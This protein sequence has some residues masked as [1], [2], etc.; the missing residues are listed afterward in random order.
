[1]TAIPKASVTASTASPSSPGRHRGTSSA[2][3]NPADEDVE[4]L[5]RRRPG[6]HLDRRI[7]VDTHRPVDPE[8][9]RRV[10]AALDTPT[11]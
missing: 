7:P 8:I 5:A 9:L 2:D 1:M 3:P 4:P 11:R 10:L 6:R